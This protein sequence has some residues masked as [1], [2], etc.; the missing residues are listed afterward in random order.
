M[1]YSELSLLCTSTQSFRKFPVGEEWF[2]NHLF[3]SECY[4]R[5]PISLKVFPRKHYLLTNRDLLVKNRSPVTDIDQHCKYTMYMHVFF[6]SSLS[7]IFLGK[8][9]FIQIFFSPRSV[10]WLTSS[11]LGK[12]F[13]GYSCQVG[14]LEE[15]GK[16]EILFSF[17][18]SKTSAMG[19]KAPKCLL[20]SCEWFSESTQ[21][22]IHLFIHLLFHY[23]F[24][25][26][27]FY[28]SF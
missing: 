21:K 19:H 5:G 24:I 25:L 26:I 1:T 18:P 8:N 27:D 14:I 10:E 17:N 2:L 3:S 12:H 11:I 7:V 20:F 28:I 13:T 16:I 6:S 15:I 9:V 4:Y 22:N 23:I